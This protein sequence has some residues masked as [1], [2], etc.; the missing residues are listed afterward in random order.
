M[1]ARIFKSIAAARRWRASFAGTAD[2]LAV[3]AGSFR[4]LHPGNLRCIARAAAKYPRLCLVVESGR[5]GPPDNIGLLKCVRGV[6]ALVA[7]RREKM[8]RLLRTLQ[9]YTLFDCMAQQ[10]PSAANMAARACAHRIVRVAAL[11]G[12]F[13]RDIL[14]AMS[15]NR[16]PLT[17]PNLMGQE[18]PAKRLRRI[19]GR[20]K[21]VK[22]A[23]VNGSFDILHAGHARLLTQ[24]RMMG[25]ALVVLVNDDQSVRRHKGPRRPVFGIGARLAALESLEPVTAAVPFSGDNP[26]K[27]LGRLRPAVHV[28]GGSF[29]PER[30]RMEEKLLASWGGRIA[31][32]PM[33]K[34][35]STTNVIG[36]L[37]DRP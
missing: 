20:M 19:A 4:M 22:I 29:I 2:E 36:A 30:V 6:A 24:A 8:P 31:F 21:G 33:Y 27:A 32:V 13:T 11:K 37:S 7:A 17:V 26:L 10:D 16:L 34:K 12:F 3:V 9:P 23:S 1:A 15:A 5:G 35:H 25:R 18:S 14:A 28:K